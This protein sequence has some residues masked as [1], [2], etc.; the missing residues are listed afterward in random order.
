[1]PSEVI[2][3]GKVL[4]E[5]ATARNTKG[6]NELKALGANQGYKVN[7]EAVQE[8]ISFIRADLDQKTGELI[9]LIKSEGRT[10]ILP[11]D[12]VRIFSRGGV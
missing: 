9:E 7:G 4:R 10:V 11:R 1:M 2:N 12:I 8:V 3:I 5:E 6:M